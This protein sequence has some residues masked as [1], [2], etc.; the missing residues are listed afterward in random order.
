MFV[1]EADRLLGRRRDIDAK[2]VRAE[3]SEFLT[4]WHGAVG[5]TEKAKT[6]FVLLAT[7]TPWDIDP[8]A[9]RRA[10]IRIMNGLPRNEDRVRN[11]SIYLR[12]EKLNE[13]ETVRN[14]G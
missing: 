11:L 3:L 13:N 14:A 5:G 1:D 4:Q 7:N 6:P 9:L 2:H 8:A 10:P 12:E